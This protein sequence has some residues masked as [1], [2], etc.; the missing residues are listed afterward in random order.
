MSTML[1][2]FL[3]VSGEKRLYSWGKA[4]EGNKSDDLH[5]KT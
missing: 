2:I 4:K 5:N 3:R 1:N